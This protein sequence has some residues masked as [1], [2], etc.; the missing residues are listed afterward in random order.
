MEPKPDDVYML[1]YTSGTTGDPKSVKLTHKM[2]MNGVYAMQ[3]PLAAA[4]LNDED[5]YISYL[6]AAH[7][8]EQALFASSLIYGV[9]CGFFAGNV[10]MLTKD[11]AVLKPTLFPSVP[12]L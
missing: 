6:P 1:S 4:P 7:A 2:M 8:F 3:G 12:R 10:L 11:V 5:C 9:R